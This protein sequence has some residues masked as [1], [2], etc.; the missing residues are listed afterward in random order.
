[1][2]ARKRG[3]ETPPMLLGHS[4]AGAGWHARMSSRQR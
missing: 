3:V 2:K 4:F 1:V